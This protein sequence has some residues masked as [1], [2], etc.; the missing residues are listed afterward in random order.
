MRATLSACRC[1]VD[2]AHINH[3]LE[4][5][6]RRHGRRR[7]AVLTR[8]GLGDDALFSHP[9]REQDLA[10]RVVDFVRAG[11]EQIFA[12]QI[13]LRAA[14][15][16]RQ[17]LR[18]IKRRRPARVFAQQERE[19]VLKRFVLSRLLVFGG[20]VVQ[21]RHQRLGHEHAAVRAEVAARVG[22]IFEV[23]HVAQKLRGVL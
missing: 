9:L 7:D 8:A 17:P 3:A 15:F 13:N 19:F 5:R 2:R 14:E 18:E 10:E 23:N 16:A 11:V 4:A 21:R 1:H 12:L 20:Q 22:E 6:A